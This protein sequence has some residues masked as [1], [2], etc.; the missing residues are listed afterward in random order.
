MIV[1]EMWVEEKSK[2]SIIILSWKDSV[3]RRAICLRSGV[4]LR[5]STVSKNRDRKPKVYIGHVTD[6]K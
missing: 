3:K 5:L 1:E 6:L 2:D 4:I